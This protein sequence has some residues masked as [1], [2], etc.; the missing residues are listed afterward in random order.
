MQKDRALVQWTFFFVR[1][2]EKVIITFMKYFL[3]ETKIVD[4]YQCVFCD[5]TYDLSL[6]TER[7]DVKLQKR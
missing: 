5:E 3:D 1:G 2:V 6:P 4:I 7:A